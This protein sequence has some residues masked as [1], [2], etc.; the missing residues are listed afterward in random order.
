MPNNLHSRRA[1]VGATAIAVAGV[2]LWW[3]WRPAPRVL[4]EVPRHDVIVREGRL[5][6]R[7][8]GNGPFTGIM[9][10]NFAP[11]KPKT[12][13]PVEAGLVHGVSQGWYENGQLEVTEPFSHGVSHGVRIRW[14]DNG[15]K[16]SEA[17]IVQGQLDGPFTEWHPNGTKALTMTMVHGLGEGPCEAWH[18]DGAKKSHILLKAGE[19]VER[20]FFAAAKEGGK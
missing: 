18:P 19:P 2:S 15:Q 7:T 13:V 1:W 11:G 10:E 8:G 12:R 6:L 20:E 16:K 17:I 14:H 5:T 9:V 4:S 3:A